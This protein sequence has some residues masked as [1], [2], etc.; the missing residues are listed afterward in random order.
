LA[1]PAMAAQPKGPACWGATKT[2]CAGQR[3]PVGGRFEVSGGRTSVVY[4]LTDSERCLGASYGLFN[5]LG[6]DAS[7]PVSRSGTF[8][9]RGKAR[10]IGLRRFSVPVRLSGR[11]VTPTLAKVAVTISYKRCKTVH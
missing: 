1:I 8:S 9:Y 11:F 6:I 5:E 4:G 10:V 7:M 2:G 3:G